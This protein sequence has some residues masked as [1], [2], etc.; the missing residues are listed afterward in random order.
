M[1]FSKQPRVRLIRPLH[2][3]RIRAAS[4]SLLYSSRIRS[5]SHSLC[6][7]GTDLYLK[8]QRVAANRDASLEDCAARGILLRDLLELLEFAKRLLD[9]SW[10]VDDDA[11]S[12][13]FGARVT[14][15]NA[16][17]YHLCKHFIKPLTQG[18]GCSYVE[19]VSDEPHLPHWMISHWWGTPLAHT[20]AM[21]EYHAKMRQRVSGV[22]DFQDVSYWCCTLANRQHDLSE[23]QKE[24]SILESPFAKVLSSNLCKGTV[25]LVDPAAVPLTRVWC[26]FELFLTKR[27]RSG[28]FSKDFHSLDV[29]TV[30]HVEVAQGDGPNELEQTVVVL[31]DVTERNWHT[32][33]ELGEVPFPRAVIQR[34][35]RVDICG[36]EASVAE[37]KHKIM[38]YIAGEGSSIWECQLH[39]EHENYS[40]LDKFISDVFRSGELHNVIRERPPDM[41]DQVKTLLASGADPNKLIDGNNALHTAVQS[42]LATAAVPEN[43]GAAYTCGVDAIQEL[44]DMLLDAGG[45]PNHLNST[46][47][48]VLD[49]A[50]G[51][52]ANDSTDAVTLLQSRG[53]QRHSDLIGDPD[54]DPNC[55][56]QAALKCGFARKTRRS[57][58]VREA[59]AYWWHVV[60]TR[61]DP[62]TPDALPHVVRRRAT[63][64][65]RS[66]STTPSISDH[67]SDDSL[68]STVCAGAELSPA[69]IRSLRKVAVILKEFPDS[70][71]L[72]SQ[73]RA[74]ASPALDRAVYV[75][76]FLE[77]AGCTNAF[78]IQSTKQRSDEWLHLW[79]EWP[80][81][82]AQNL[83]R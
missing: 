41:I 35:A 29:A 69:E 51:L 16:T 4:R 14:I 15:E 21:L 31:Q 50:L 19:A 7:D 42:L 79:L 6:F 39:K 55:R 18:Y 43:A 9:R 11:C 81:V 56:L 17:M 46:G 83:N 52:A 53:A 34:G 68:S 74:E 32:S 38:N 24:T 3:S 65:S 23:L 33:S 49:C 60:R 75:Q 63:W 45:D 80:G 72:I 26:V 30:A 76:E 77:A 82:L 71:C 12:P 54:R 57:F 78:K 58:T 25:L 27:L 1:A 20:A 66:A 28:E 2:S 44:V 40:K 48:T 59:G 36:A 47:R 73:V 5:A 13:I 62:L 8:I 64:A 37:D 70:P 61:A 10:I 22:E 67:S